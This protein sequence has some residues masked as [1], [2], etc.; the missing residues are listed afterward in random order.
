[1]LEIV[2]QKIG[3]N[4]KYEDFKE[5]LDLAKNWLDQCSPESAYKLRSVRLGIL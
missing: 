3:M 1:M 5:R 2:F 4:Y